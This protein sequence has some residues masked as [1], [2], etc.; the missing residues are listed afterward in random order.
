MKRRSRPF[1]TR[2]QL[3]EV[4]QLRGARL[5]VQPPSLDRGQQVGPELVDLIDAPDGANEEEQNSYPRLIS[6]PGDLLS[7]GPR[8][9]MSD[10]CLGRFIDLALVPEETFP[11]RALEFARS[12][13]LLGLCRHD[14]PHLHAHPN[15]TCALQS[16]KWR[17][18]LLVQWE[19]LASWRR[20]SRHL[21]ALLRV[22]AN[23]QN[24]R[25]G[26]REDWE[27]IFDA[28]PSDPPRE[29][30]LREDYLGDGRVA[31]IPSRSF[32]DL[33]S[34]KL[35]ISDIVTSWLRFGAAVP[36]MTWFVPAAR[37]KINFFR[38]SVV[39]VLALQLAAVAQ[40]PSGLY[41]CASCRQPFT[42]PDASRRR[43]WNRNAYCER[44]GCGRRAN[45]RLSQ[46]RFQARRGRPA[47]EVVPRV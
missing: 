16:M 45:N 6:T 11:F 35:M 10:D 8:Y 2:D 19:P 9:G 23:L 44:D 20:Y 29:D 5:E 40:A 38:L 22:V 15:R 4:I 37:P 25:L 46:R 21:S 7:Q 30:L 42:L 33:E 17:N 39:G 3:D 47:T 32:D 14:E 43:A 1:S 13:G 28:M 27:A 26:S 12:F 41:I 36:I 34:G 18:D 31:W 24:D